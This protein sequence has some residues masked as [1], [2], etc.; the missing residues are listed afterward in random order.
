MLFGRNS[1]TEIHSDSSNLLLVDFICAFTH[2]SL[3]FH[4]CFTHVS[5]ILITTEMVHGWLI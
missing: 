2:V 4:S 5:L 1:S 3:M